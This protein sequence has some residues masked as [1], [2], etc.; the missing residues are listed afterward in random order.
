MCS[1]EGRRRSHVC[2]ATL[3]RPFV[4]NS[5][6]GL[7]A[8][9]QRHHFLDQLFV[10]AQQLVILERELFDLLFK[11]SVHF[12][13]LE[14][15]LREFA[16]VRYGRIEALPS[17]VQCQTVALCI[18]RSFPKA[19]KGR[20]FQTTMSPA[21]AFESAGRELFRS[22]YARHPPTASPSRRGSRRPTRPSLS[23]TLRTL[24]VWLKYTYRMTKNC[25][26][27]SAPPMAKRLDRAIPKAPSN[28][29]LLN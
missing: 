20:H 18:A 11:Y 27:N 22:P 24:D 29:L 13:Q 17:G 1:V 9:T 5:E 21:L 3:P 15:C 14:V 10:G 2:W 12:G 16:V 23:S 25:N 4:E 26:R 7:Q 8:V 19:R 28:R 6:L